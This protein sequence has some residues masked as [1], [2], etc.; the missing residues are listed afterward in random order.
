PLLRRPVGPLADALTAVGAEVDAAGG[1]P[2]VRVAGG[3]LDGGAATVDASASSQFASALLLVAPYARADLSVRAAGAGAVG[4]VALTAELMSSW[5][6][7]ARQ[8]AADT[9]QVTAGRGY[10]GGTHRVEYDASAAAHLLAVAVA[11]GGRVTVT[12][13][14]PRTLQP[15]AAVTEVFA[16]MGATVRRSDQELTVTG[17]ARP[18]PVDV[19]LAAMPDQLP[20]VAV[21]A[22]L[23]AGTSRVRG[24]A[25]ARLHESDRLAALAREL[26]K[27]GVTVD[28]RPAELRIHGGRPSGPARLRTYH[29]HRLAMA[30]AALAARVPGIVVE[31]PWCVTKTYPR[32]WHDL[33]GLGVAWQ[34]D[35]R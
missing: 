16:A 7:E 30:F 8:V 1:F 3:G 4:Y 25:V 27:L 12:N 26:G 9:W 22:A 23:A 2:P 34:E 15:D 32:F 10:R 17:P 35:S 24:V 18:D 14:A 11:T 6:A 19:D 31:E 20:T 13:A 21:L 28:E 33:R 29:D 5:G